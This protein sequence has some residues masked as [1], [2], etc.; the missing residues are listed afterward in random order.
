MHIFL[1]WAVSVFNMHLCWSNG[2]NQSTLNLLLLP[3]RDDQMYWLGN[4]VWEIFLLLIILCKKV[5]LVYFC[6]EPDSDLN[7]LQQGN[8]KE[9]EVGGL[10]QNQPPLT[11]QLCSLSLSP[12]FCLTQTHTP[13][14]TPSLCFSQFLASSACHMMKIC[15]EMVSREAVAFTTPQPWVTG[16]HSFTVNWFSINSQTPG[17]QTNVVLFGLL[18]S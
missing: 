15:P 3:N 13:P 14:L 18:A 17:L 2:K 6:E 1:Y 4:T 5:M 11:H 8:W 10:R 9:G 12:C 7:I 16:C